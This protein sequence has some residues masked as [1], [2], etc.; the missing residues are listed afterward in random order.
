MDSEFT[1]LSREARMRRLGELC[2]KAITLFLADHTESGE[3]AA[4]SQMGEFPHHGVGKKSIETIISDDAKS[5]IAYLRRVGA[6]SPREICQ[7]TELSRTTV[8]RRLRELG[9]SGIV[10]KTG[11]TSAAKYAI[12]SPS[13]I[14]SEIQ[15]LNQVAQVR[16]SFAPPESR[17]AVL[18]A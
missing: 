7:Y 11:H 16:G 2:S 13:A 17:Q 12:A 14:T 8:F 4:R 5:I 3:S 18:S 1:I 6:S 10:I 15:E 9:R